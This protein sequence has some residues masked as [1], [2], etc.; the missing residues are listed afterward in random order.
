MQSYLQYRRFGQDVQRRVN[1]EKSKRVEPSDPS[2][3]STTSSHTPSSYRQQ[4]TNI[5]APDREEQ[6][7]AGRSDL[8]HADQDPELEQFE[9]VQQTSTTIGH[10]L[11]DVSP[12]ERATRE[13]KGGQVFVVGWT[14]EADPMN[15][16]NWSSLA[17]LMVIFRIALIS[18]A[19]TMASSIDSTILP[20][21]AR[22]FGVSE[23]AESL[24]TGNYLIGF[25][26][27]TLLA[28]PLS[29]TLGRNFIYMGSLV[30]FMCWIVGCA[31]APNFGAQ[32]TFRWLAGF[33][34]S[35]SLTVSGG[36]IAD[37]Y[38]PLSK[39]YA[40]PLYAI[41]GFGGPILGPVIGAYIGPANDRGVISWKWV[42]WVSLIAAALT[43]V[44]I[45]LFQPETYAPL[46]LRWKVS[47]RSRF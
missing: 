22:D 32:I 19:V 10:A 21:A 34:G 6:Q 23:V 2:E 24:A 9:Q 15:P 14:G 40:F 31:L 20:Q 33:F 17:K 44:V 37:L 47:L 39:T 45:V 8:N 1:A 4:D 38:D 42:E 29:E 28:G 16:H 11:E 12:R 36:S 13:G 43:L 41:S 46:L 5:A 30:A 27:G 18:F 7:L 35:P 25:G 26:C 3:T